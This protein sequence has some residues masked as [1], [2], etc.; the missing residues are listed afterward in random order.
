MAIVWK[1]QRDCHQPM[2]LTKPLLV[3]KVTICWLWLGLFSTNLPKHSTNKSYKGIAEKMGKTKTQ[4]CTCIASYVQSPAQPCTDTCFSSSLSGQS[5]FTR[6]I[7]AGFIILPYLMSQPCL[8]SGL[9][10]FLSSWSRDEVPRRSKMCNCIDLE[11]LGSNTY[12]A[13]STHQSFN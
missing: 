4:V 8:V 12:I 5:T 2:I 13:N 11:Y 1:N 9:G 7:A 3:K 10:F 6:C